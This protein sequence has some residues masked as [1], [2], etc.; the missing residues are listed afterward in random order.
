M[1]HEHEETI[2]TKVAGGAIT[3]TKRVKFCRVHGAID[4]FYVGGAAAWEARHAD[5]GTQQNP[6]AVGLELPKAMRAAA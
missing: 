2:K 6:G 4:L 1:T 5:C 3:Y